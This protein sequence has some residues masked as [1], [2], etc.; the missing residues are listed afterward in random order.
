MRYITKLKT[1]DLAQVAKFAYTD[2]TIRPGLNGVHFIAAAG[3]PLVLVATDGRRMA[4]VTLKDSQCES[5]FTATIPNCA[6]ESICANEKAQVIVS[7][8]NSDFLFQFTGYQIRVTP[9]PNAFP[10]YNV[11]FPT[12]MPDKFAGAESWRGNHDFIADCSALLTHWD[13]LSACR[14]VTFGASDALFFLSD[15][16]KVSIRMALM[17]MRA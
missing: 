7:E 10:N 2:S 5:D 3:K 6:I 12:P 8:L 16:P 4:E 1:S 9:E 17:P 13:G 14:L 11:I 15:T